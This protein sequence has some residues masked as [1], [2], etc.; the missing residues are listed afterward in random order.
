V[1]PAPK[2][3]LVN[4]EPNAKPS[5]RVKSFVRLRPLGS[6]IPSP[7]LDGSDKRP[8]PVPPPAAPPSPGNGAWSLQTP[9]VTLEKRGMPRLRAGET[10]TYQIVVRNLG[11][12]PAQQVRIEEE[13]PGA[14]KIVS[15]EPMPAIEGSR[16]VWTLPLVDVHQQQTLR[17]GLRAL[18]DVDI[19]N[20]LTVN[21]SASSQ[22]TIALRPRQLGDGLAVRLAGPASASVGKP[23]VFEIQVANQ[24][25][26]PIDGM[27]LRG[28]LPEGLYH[29]GEGRDIQGKVEGLFLP[30]QIK[31]LKMPAAAVKPGR[32]SVQVKVTT[33]TG[34]EA[35][36]A[37]GID[38]LGDGVLLQQAPATQLVLGRD[39]DL[40]I[41][42]TNHSGRP[43]KN[44]V[45][46]D[47]LPDGVDFVAASERG[48]FQ[49][50]SRTVHWLIG[51]LP[52]G[53]TQTLYVRVHGMKTGEHAN[54]VHAKADGLA[55]LESQGVI[56]LD[57]M[58]ELSLRV[59][60]PDMV[61]ELGR[62]TVYEIQLQNPGSMSASN[63]QVQVQFGPGLTPRRADPNSRCTID[64]HLVTFEPIPT[65]GPQG[66]AILRV[67][68]LAQGLGDQRVHVAVVS[69]QV[70]TPI[71]REISTRVVHD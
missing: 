19:A 46:A 30:G 8:A 66:Q 23:V 6:D 27:V 34:L 38:I 71:Q 36:A 10:Q 29:P 39:G 52:A 59:A 21:V 18:N 63:V 50:N 60:N 45:V 3:E 13:L 12:V 67:T 35:I 16:A 69:D 65:L 64:R 68:A 58:A 17:F 11:P 14:V 33:T 5:E 43:L 42:L 51:Q 25:G 32:Y 1:I 41:E 53:K 15:G 24:T 54:V 44:V 26:Q 37:T 2:Q 57:G 70:R 62:E 40:R 55:Q 47:R 61:I 7:L 20:R 48:L 22:N 4:P 28:L 49:A 56:R 31:I 9:S